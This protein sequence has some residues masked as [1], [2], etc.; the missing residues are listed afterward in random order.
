MFFRH[1]LFAYG[2]RPFFFFCGLFAL[3]VIPAWLLIRIGEVSP[4]SD[5]PAQL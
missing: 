1:P 4:F 3:L 5:L 2:F